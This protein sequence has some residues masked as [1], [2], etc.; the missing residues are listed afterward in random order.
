M[1]I[2][3]IIRENLVLAV[4]GNREPLKVWGL[5]NTKSE[6]CFKQVNLKLMHRSD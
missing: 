6:V 2:V 4:V 5:G 3:L 1:W